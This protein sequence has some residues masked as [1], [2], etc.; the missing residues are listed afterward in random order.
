MSET[1]QHILTNFRIQH[2]T[3]SVGSLLPSL[4]FSCIHVFFSFT[5][6]DANKNKEIEM[7]HNHKNCP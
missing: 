2:Q 5:L 6:R 3:S 7:N 4:P 1:F